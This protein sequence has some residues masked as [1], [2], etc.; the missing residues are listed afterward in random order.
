MRSVLRLVICLI[1]WVLT[2]Y[3]YCL[4]VKFKFLGRSWVD[5]RNFFTSL[6]QLFNIIFIG[7]PRFYEILV[8]LFFFMSRGW[9]NIFSCHIYKTKYIRY[10]ISTVSKVSS[11]RYSST[12]CTVHTGT[13]CRYGTLIF[14]V[15]SRY[16]TVLFCK[17]WSMNSTVYTAHLVPM[18]MFLTDCLCCHRILAVMCIVRLVRGTPLL[19]TAIKQVPYL[20]FFTAQYGT[21]TIPAWYLTYCT[22]QYRTV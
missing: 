8:L 2:A 12:V 19:E 22:L 4:S 16:G 18:K 3:G 15:V 5:I 10:L 20:L 13:T 11:Y 9:V 17:I 21:V 7:S 1:E 6:S 14:W